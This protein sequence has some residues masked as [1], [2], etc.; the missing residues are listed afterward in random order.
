VY[1]RVLSTSAINTAALGSYLYWGEWVLD[2]GDYQPDVHRFISKASELEA[3]YSSKLDF[4]G[5]VTRPASLLYA[6]NQPT[7]IS[8]YRMDEDAGVLLLPPDMDASCWAST[9]AKIVVGTR[10]G[11][12]MLVDF[13]DW[14][15][16]GKEGEEFVVEE[17]NSDDGY[18]TAGDGADAEEDEDGMEDFMSAIEGPMSRRGS[19]AP[20]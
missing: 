14:S 4:A 8:S 18:E 19:A 15:I 6:A 9:R 2:L 20:I 3:N 1:S 10:N 12:V 5:P 17:P 7:R 11:V 16:L 13:V